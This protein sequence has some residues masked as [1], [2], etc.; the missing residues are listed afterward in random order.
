MDKVDRSRTLGENL[1]RH[2]LSGLAALLPVILTV[3]IIALALRLTN[4]L[5]GNYI[6]H[7][8]REKYG[9][10]IPGLGLVLLGL[11]VMGAG[12]FVN[13]FLGG[14]IFKL[15]EKLLYRIP[16]VANIYPAARKLS[17]FLFKAENNR[18]FRKV[19][20]VEYPTSGS[21]SIGFLTNEGVEQFNCATGKELVTVL[22]PLSPM[23][24]SG[25]LLVLPREKMVEVDMKINEAV[26]LVLSGGVVVPGSSEDK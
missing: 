8:L 9:F 21:Y 19:V 11:M 7:I 16:L 13:N 5:A 22:V 14:K 23:P 26:G 1:R 2:F 25:L 12:M 18:Q 4:N 10:I 17:D 15:T 6:N 3:Y 20:L 24:Y